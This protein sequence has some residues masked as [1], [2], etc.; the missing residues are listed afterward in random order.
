MCALFCVEVLILYPTKFRK[1]FVVLHPV[2][3]DYHSRCF[4]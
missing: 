2:L 3:L 4:G 1:S